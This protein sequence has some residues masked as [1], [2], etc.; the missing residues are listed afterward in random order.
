MLRNT[1]LSAAVALAS[2]A[3]LAAV[4]ATASAQPPVRHEWHR[5]KFEVLIRDCG[6]WDCY[7]TYRDRDD[8]YRAAQHLRMRGYEVRVE[9]N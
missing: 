6:R 5:P 1:V 3:G 2:L 8:A 4:P 9:R 7:G